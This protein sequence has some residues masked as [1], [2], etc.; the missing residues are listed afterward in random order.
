MKILRGAL[1]CTLMAMIT[2]CGSGRDL[3]QER[4]T[5]GDFYEADATGQ[6]NNSGNS[7][8]N[9]NGTGK[10]DSN[11]EGNNN[12]SD[13]PIIP[14]ENFDPALKLRGEIQDVTAIGE[15]YGWAVFPDDASVILT[16]D[17]YIDGDATTGTL[18]GSQIANLEGFDNG[19]DGNHAFRAQIPNEFRDGKNH[20][21]TAFADINGNV[22]PVF[23]KE[24]NFKAYLPTQAGQ[25]YYANTLRP[26]LQTSCGGCH[27]GN[28]APA[29]NYNA[30]YDYIL[31]PNPAKTGTALDNTLINKASGGMNH[32]GGNRCG[33]NGKNGNP[34]AQIQTW[35][36]MEFGTN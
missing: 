32:S 28:L 18:L 3:K 8:D 10:A 35:W 31:S 9:N 1:G 11:S 19:Y 33:G 22:E 20:T 2:A 12:P 27:G 7:P 25:A 21:I 34:C 36:N 24:F 6:K 4:T 17:I 23:S 15:V 5:Y 13:T 16:V 26:L 14:D 29:V 30:Q